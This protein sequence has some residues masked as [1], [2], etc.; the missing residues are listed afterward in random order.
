[1]LTAA[2][3]PD[4]VVRIVLSKR[5]CALVSPKDHQVGK[6]VCIFTHR[7]HVSAQHQHLLVCFG[8]LRVDKLV[9][10]FSNRRHQIPSMTCNTITLFSRVSY[11]HTLNTRRYTSQRRKWKKGG[12]IWG[13]PETERDWERWI[14]DDRNIYTGV[15]EN[16]NK[17]RMKVRYQYTGLDTYMSVW[18]RSSSRSKTKHALEIPRNP[19]AICLSRCIW[20]S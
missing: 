1:M 15:R 20:T 16:L 11:Q 18:H 10:G 17:K 9:V 5:Q 8:L 13:V 7:R 6:P 4:D 12:T 14:K 2:R 19:R 3:L